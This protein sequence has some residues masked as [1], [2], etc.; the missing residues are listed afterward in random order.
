MSQSKSY[1]SSRQKLARSRS[2]NDH[3]GQDH[4]DISNDLPD[5]FNGE[6]K[7]LLENLSLNNNEAQTAAVENKNNH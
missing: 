6:S 4:S 5:V 3:G 7:I 2:G 1:V